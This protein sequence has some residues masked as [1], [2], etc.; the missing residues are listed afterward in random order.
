ML[1]L[2]HTRW[3]SE[4]GNKTR[5]PRAL[6]K[7]GTSWKQIT[8]DYTQMMASNGADTL[9]SHTKDHGVTW[10][11]LRYVWSP[12]NEWEEWVHTRQPWWCVARTKELRKD[13]V[14]TDHWRLFALNSERPLTMKSSKA[15][16]QIY[17]S[18]LLELIIFLWYIYD[19]YPI[20]RLIQYYALFL[21]WSW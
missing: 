16:V 11:Y 6:A 4:V 17:L 5:T 18:I 1:P 19:S 13:D 2:D 12:A 14:A 3:N 7:E 21:W 10:R 8:M 9:G 15:K 20:V